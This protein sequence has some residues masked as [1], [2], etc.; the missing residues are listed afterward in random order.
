MEASGIAHISVFGFV[1]GT[2]AF[3]FKQQTVD[4]DVN[5]DG[6]IETATSG[7]ASARA[8]PGPD[9][10]NATLTTLGLRIP[11]GKGLT[12]GTADGPGFSIDSGAF[13]LAMVSPSAADQAAGD[14]RSWLALTAEIDGGTFTG[15]P[16]FDMTV[17]SLGL[18][19]NQASGTYTPSGGTPIANRALDW[20]KAF[21]SNGAEFANGVDITTPTPTGPVTET[22]GFTDEKLRAF[23][24]VSV[25]LFGG[26]ISGE[27]GFSLELM[28]AN[29]KIDGSTTLTNA[30]LTEITFTVND[31]TIG[32]GGVGFHVTGG[33][34]ALVMV[35]PADESDHRSWLALQAD[36]TGGT[37]TGI[38]GLDFTIHTLSVG[39]NSASGTNASPHRTGRPR[40][41]STRTATSA[42]TSSSPTPPP[43]PT[44]SPSR[45]RPTSRSPAQPRSTS[46]GS[47]PATSASPSRRR[48]S[49]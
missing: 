29:V 5:G 12:I 44:R 45:V 47:S 24:Q 11:A 4:V 7:S 42:T 25:N 39:L 14:A 15:I 28:T 16:D 21:D 10:S 40:S 27:L 38:Q 1:D 41:I 37:F 20:T 32:G 2:I 36:L 8:P 43:T 30:K 49:M 22:I 6:H 33:G 34:L 13:A 19:L 3:S 23:G 31:L 17:E 35:K 46:S 48:P 26:F 18:E 9:L